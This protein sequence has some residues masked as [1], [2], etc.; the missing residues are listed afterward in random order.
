MADDAQTLAYLMKVLRSYGPV[1]AKYK[2]PDPKTQIIDDK[3]F[4]K[5][6][7]DRRVATLQ[8]PRRHSGVIPYIDNVCKGCESAHSRGLATVVCVGCHRV[9]RRLKP[10]TDKHGF[11][12]EAN[13]VYHIQVCP[14]C[15]PGI[16]YCVDDG[17]EV[18]KTPIVEMQL[19]H[20]QKGVKS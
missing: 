13:E 10:F 18:A 6:A 14:V 3:V 16:R 20:K 2:N 7:C 19:W 17:C 4:T 1:E 5:C 12:V 9:A 11:R 8:L 15:R